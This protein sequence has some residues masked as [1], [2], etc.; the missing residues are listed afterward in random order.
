MA[1]VGLH[2]LHVRPVHYTAQ[3]DI[4]RSGPKAAQTFYSLASADKQRT[5]VCSSVRFPRDVDRHQR[6]A[7][8]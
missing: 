8:N 6:T 2:R 1:S 4:D 7:G 5:A 3:I